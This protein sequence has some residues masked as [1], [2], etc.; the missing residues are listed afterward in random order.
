MKKG[1]LITFILNFIFCSLFAQ[2]NPITVSIPMRDGKFL[3][4]DIYL[5]NGD[6]IP[7]P[8]ILI[9]TP[10]QKNYYHVLGLPLQVG[11]NI[12][13]SPFNFVI[14]DWRC[15]YGSAAACTTSMNRGEDGYDVVEWIAQQPWSN[16]STGTWGP[17]A[18]GIIQFQ[19]A[20]E[21][22]PHL[23]CCVPI[24]AG[25]RTNY[26]RYYPGGVYRTEYVTMLDVLGYGLST[27]LL[28]HPVHDIYWTVAESSS[29]YPTSINVPMF[30]IGGWYDH[31]TEEVLESFEGIRT[32]SA[33]AVRSQ[34]KLLMGPWTHNTT[35]S[36]PEQVGELDYPEAQGVSDSLARKFFEYYLLNAQNGWSTRPVVEYFQMGENTWN[37]DVSWNNSG[38]T[39]YNLY[40]HQNGMMDLTLPTGVLDSEQINYDPRDPSPTIGGPVLLNTL[41]QGPYDQAPV[42]E[43]RNDI[44]SFTTLPLTQDVVLRG[45]PTVHLKVSSDKPD[46]DFSIRLTDVYPNG[47]SMLVQDGIRRM[48][49]RTGFTV[50]DTS[51][52][53]PGSIYP[54]DV[55]LFANTAITFLAGHSIRVDITSSNYPR[56]DCNLNNGQTMYVAGDTL[57]AENTVYM[58]S[59]NAS[60]ITLPLENFLDGISEHEGNDV[61]S[62]YPNP[63]N[64]KFTIHDLQCTMGAIVRIG[65]YNSLGAVVN[66]P[67]AYCLL[68]AVFDVHS[69][70]PGIYFLTIESPKGIATKRFSILR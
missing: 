9:Q 52:I 35:S 55:E 22:P 27:V 67:V 33:V 45:R 56:F 6:S 36:A 5:P 28:A 59:A 23:T 20:K 34:Q 11:F 53:S 21:N 49:F 19:T 65:I 16:D 47:K 13:S 30:M 4:A 48:R 24:V 61:F 63:V 25:M 31:A 14:A 29:Y 64:D 2:L 60:Y 41:D 51:N 66:L 18:L 26:E 54:V 1:L 12:N 69:L 44:L 37:N 50:N 38:L 40:F 7:R 57:I 42:V 68:P 8:T 3:A 10:Y 17:S 70:P 58:N 62:V 43:S 15:F 46:T 32:Q 39:D